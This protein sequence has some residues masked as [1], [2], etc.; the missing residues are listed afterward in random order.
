MLTVNDTMIDP[1]SKKPDHQRIS[2]RIDKRVERILESNQ[3]KT[4]EKES[5][6]IDQDI[7]IRSNGAPTRN[8]VRNNRKR[9]NTAR[10]NVPR[11]RKQ[12]ISKRR[13]TSS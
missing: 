8:L 11:N 3:N 7:D 6:G 1:I 13:N 2:N 9:C 12:R 4:Q 5:P 10:D